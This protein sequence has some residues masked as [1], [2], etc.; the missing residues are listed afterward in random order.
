[1]SG[2][3]DGR[4]AIVTGGSSGIGAAGARRFLEEGAAVMLAARASARAEALLAELAGAHGERVAFQPTDVADPR[5]VD[6]LVSATVERFGRLDVAYSNAGV[7]EVGDVEATS[8]EV[9]RAIIDVNLGGQFHLARAAMP[10]LARSGHGS[11]ILTASELGLVG[12]SRSVAYCA[13]KGGVVNMARAIA[14][15]CRANGV[16][17]NCLCP[18]PVETPMIRRWFDEAEDPVAFEAE[19]VDPVLLGRLGRP[20][21]IAAAA[22]F[23]ASDESTFMTGSVM[24]VD[25]GATSW[26][27]L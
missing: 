27:G 11:L 26:Y 5:A 8:D 2:K 22:L 17:V 25:G 21:E 4:V 20:H 12:T 7:Q 6:A 23:L 24:V 16:R 13:A 3:L 1:M 18:G 10:A 9:W 14:V 15:D 19:Q